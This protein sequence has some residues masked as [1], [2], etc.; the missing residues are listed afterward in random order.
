MK[1]FAMD[2]LICHASSLEFIMLGMLRLFLYAGH[3]KTNTVVMQAIV[4]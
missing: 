4:K 2:F 3:V 1:L